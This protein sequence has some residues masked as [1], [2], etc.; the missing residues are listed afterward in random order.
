MIDNRREVYGIVKRSRSENGAIN[1]S[2]KGKLQVRVEKRRR[3][4]E[5]INL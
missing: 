2:K 1:A 3:Q 4:I 5:R